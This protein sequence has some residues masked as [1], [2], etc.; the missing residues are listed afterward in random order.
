[1]KFKTNKLVRLALLMSTGVVL[2]GCPCPDDPPRPAELSIVIDE[3]APGAQVSGDSDTVTVRGRVTVVDGELVRVAVN[4]FPGFLR[5]GS[6]DG[7]RNFTAVV[8]VYSAGPFTVA[9][10]ATAEPTVTASASVSFDVVYTGDRTPP[11]LAIDEPTDGAVIDGA[12]VT[13]RGTLSEDARVTV[14]GRQLSESGRTFSTTANLR[15]GA[16]V[17]LVS[18]VD[19]AG[20]VGS[21]EVTVI[22][23]V[24]PPNLSV[25]SPAR[26]ALVGP[27]V[28]VIGAVFDRQPGDTDVTD[29]RVFVNGVEADV[30]RNS[31]VV[32]DIPVL[33]GQPRLTVVAVDAAGNR[34]T[35]V[36]P[37]R[38]RA[39][40]PALTAVS[41]DGQ[42]AT[43][44]S[45][46]AD[47]MVVQLTDAAQTAIPD[48]EIIF[49]V[50]RGSGTFAGGERRLATRTNATG[51]ASARFVVGRTAGPAN[52]VV[53]AATADGLSVAFT[54]TGLPNRTAPS[55]V[56]AARGDNAA[57]VGGAI[58][59]T[60]LIALVTDPDGNPLDNVT[61]TFDVLRGGVAVN[62]GRRAEVT[63]N[64]DGRAL[65]VA[66]IRRGTA[67]GQ[68]MIRA[69]LP[70]NPNQAYFPITVLPNSM[71]GETRV[72]GVVLSNERSPVVGATITVRNAEGSVK[73]DDDGRFALATGGQ[74]GQVMV[75]IDGSTVL[76]DTKFADL[77]V[78]PIVVEGINNV[79]NR[80]ILVPEL[81]DDGLAI[82]STIVSVEITRTDMPGFY[83]RIPAGSVTFADGSKVGELRVLSV[84]QDAVPMV[85]PDGSNPRSVIAIKPADVTF[86]PPAE[87]RMPNTDCQPA[88]AIT[89]IYSFDHEVSDW[90]AVGTGRVSDDRRS[91]VS[92]PGLGIVRGGWHVEPPVPVAPGRC[93]SAVG[94]A[95]CRRLTCDWASCAVSGTENRYPQ[96]GFSM[97][98]EGVTDP[99]PSPDDDCYAA[100]SGPVPCIALLEGE[101]CQIVAREFGD[102]CTRRVQV[103]FDA[104]GV[105][106]RE[107]IAPEVGTCR[108][109]ENPGGADP[110]DTVLGVSVCCPDD[111]NFCQPASGITCANHEGDACCRSACDANG[112]CGG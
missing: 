106:T 56:I 39:D 19:D 22:R 97:P 72:S 82:T 68:T 30:A 79:L 45:A 69:S 25:T 107:C 31:F 5:E 60:P 11:V 59:E 41:G 40:G 23:D 98:D 32:R 80:P 50:A 81:N 55:L 21:A 86:D 78:E 37:V 61:V 104:D 99:M 46:A 18:A 14:A 20:N 12:T 43:V 93:I 62:G 64:V 111:A 67:P 112:C 58:V 17:I 65:A 33:P 95:T 54:V 2:F 88:G 57:A 34:E 38:R 89:P 102:S 110:N 49:S 26:G 100:E 36:V 90:V 51:Q 85:P 24:T 27:R 77:A 47:P 10:L 1:M 101:D 42:S 76:G 96:C 91:I 66:E 71:A 92:E 84:N 87:F 15:E 108:F 3:P 74:V 9:A 73:T 75:Q 29:C 48:A 44:L 103:A 94:P 8:P 13:V 109:I 83:L 6:N 105:E 4:N 35:V 70:N 63:S 53:T 7:E 28:S 16:N 52:N